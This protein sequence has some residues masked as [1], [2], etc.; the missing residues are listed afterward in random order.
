MKPSPRSHRRSLITAGERWGR[1][2]VAGIPLVDLSEPLSCCI[3][4]DPRLI[5]A[6]ARENRPGDAGE[7]IGKGDRQHV[8]GRDPVRPTAEP[9]CYAFPPVRRVSAW[10]QFVRRRDFI[11]LLG[12]T[13]ATW[14]LA[15]RAQQPVIGVLYNGSTEQ[16]RSPLIGAFHQG[17]YE[18]GYVEGRNVKIEYRSW[19]NKE[20]LAKF[21]TELVADRVDLI[22]APTTI[23]AIAAKRATSTIPIVTITAGNPVGVGLAA[24]LARP[25]GNVTGLSSQ[26]GDITKRLGLLA[27]AAVSGSPTR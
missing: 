13:A 26:G 23:D 3:G 2:G 18:T 14:P 19:D 12:G 20:Q 6:T 9:V 17:L 24:S 10:G 21:A 22:V 8:A 5:G 25:G 7:L 27:E 16:Q 4:G 11:A 15:V 1:R